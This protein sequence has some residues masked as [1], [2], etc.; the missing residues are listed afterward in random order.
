M[1]DNNGYR[2]SHA[3][4][5][6]SEDAGGRHSDGRRRAPPS[7][8]RACKLD[9]PLIVCDKVADDQ[10]VP[11]AKSTKSAVSLW[12]ANPS[13]PNAYVVASNACP[14]ISTSGSSKKTLRKLTAAHAIQLLT[15]LAGRLMQR[16]SSASFDLRCSF[17]FAIP[18]CLTL[19]MLLHPFY[20]RGTGVP[21]QAWCLTKTWS[22]R[23]PWT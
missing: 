10:Q 21:Q 20:L 2:L 13:V 1:G 15:R 6:S 12:L 17:S 18:I 4:K 3:Q 7:R 14:T 16:S 11:N 8:M 9:M 5:R 23:R 19:N 22:W